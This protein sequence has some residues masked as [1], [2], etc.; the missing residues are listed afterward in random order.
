MDDVK[1]MGRF[2]DHT[3]RR[4]E[5][6]RTV[7]EISDFRLSYNFNITK[8]EIE[9]KVFNIEY[10]FTIEYKEDVGLVVVE[11]ALSYKDTP[12]ALKDLSKNWD[13]NTVF[14]QRLFN[15]IFRN[16]VTM[17]MDLSRHLDLPAPIFFPEIRPDQLK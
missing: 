5:C 16:A 11:G 7:D 9:N 12:K 2:T 1:I 15:L 17:V 10:T 14:Q 8:K 6:K 4:V 3:V 13:E